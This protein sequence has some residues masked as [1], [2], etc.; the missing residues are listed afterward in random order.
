MDEV[1]SLPFNRNGWDEKDMVHEGLVI[2]NGNVSTK[3]FLLHHAFPTL[4]YFLSKYSSLH[5]EELISKNKSTG[6]IAV[7]SGLHRFVKEYFFKLGIRDGRYGLV[8]ALY[9]FYYNFTKIAKTFVRDEVTNSQQKTQ[10]FSGLAV[11]ST[12]ILF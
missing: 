10:A 5:A 8:L 4:E 1:W 12:K 9:G 6:F 7:S 3:G 11:I 2:T